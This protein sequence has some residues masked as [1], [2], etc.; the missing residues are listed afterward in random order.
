MPT[1]DWNREAWGR[2]HEWEEG[3]DE[4]SGMAAH[5]K[6]PYPEWKRGLIEAFL[7]PHLGPDRD[8]VEIA[9]GHGR[10]SETIIPAS[11]SVRLVDLNPECLQACKERFADA[12]TVDYIQTDGSSIPVDDASADFVWSFDSFVHIDPPDVFAY[13]G[14]LAR[15]LR[16]GGYAVIHHADKTDLGLTIAPKLADKGKP[17]KVATRVV[18][19][20][21]LKGDGNRSDLNGRMVAERAEEVGLRVVQQTDRWGPGGRMTVA[22][23]HDVITTFHQPR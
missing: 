5:C 13:I 7:L 1:K 2:E 11:R 10:W 3:G 20:H 18:A 15:V 23:Y 22:R 21:L 6:V 12:T 16:P 14:E 4:W 19:Q 9:P 8:V 17:G